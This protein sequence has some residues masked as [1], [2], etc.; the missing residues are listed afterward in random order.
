MLKQSDWAANYLAQGICQYQNHN[1]SGWN[2]RCS[3]VNKST[4]FN[5]RLTNMS[6]QSHLTETDCL[7]HLITIGSSS[8]PSTVPRA[9]KQHLSNILHKIKKP[10]KIVLL[11]Q[12]PNFMNIN[13]TYVHTTIFHSYA[14]KIA[15]TQKKNMH[16]ILIKS[17]CH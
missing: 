13:H 11:K 2:K 10:V 15:I 1:T 17:I 5:Q 12:I 9:S 4:T 7:N 8:L 14:I 3:Q 6:V 16:Y